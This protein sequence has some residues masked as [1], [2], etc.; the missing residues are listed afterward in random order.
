MT[1]ERELRLFMGGWIGGIVATHIPW[2]SGLGIIVVIV[3]SCAVVKWTWWW[4]GRAALEEQ[5]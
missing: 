5:P 3:V 4:A 2:W 1:D